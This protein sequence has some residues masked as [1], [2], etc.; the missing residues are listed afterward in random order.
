MRYFDVYITK[1]ISTNEKNGIVTFFSSEER[2]F[3]QKSRLKVE[4]KANVNLDFTNV[5][6]LPGWKDANAYECFDSMQR[7]LYSDFFKNLSDNFKSQ[8]QLLIE[9]I[10]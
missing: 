6:D 8:F 5:Q 3:S 9:M 2:Q 1:S 4:Q 7:I 10:C